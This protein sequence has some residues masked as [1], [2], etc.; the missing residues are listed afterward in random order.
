MQ[1][2]LR[3]QAEAEYQAEVAEREARFAADSAQLRNTTALDLNEA[4]IEEE[5]EEEEEDGAPS[6]AR[7]AQ[8]RSSG[9][10]AVAAAMAA[11]AEM[12]KE[13]TVRQ[14]V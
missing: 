5:D 8:P 3:A 12:V 10:A 2:Q 6:G 1:Q 4:I 7:I 13:L 9:E 14:Y 11:Q